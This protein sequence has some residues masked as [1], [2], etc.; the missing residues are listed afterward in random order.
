MSTP[1]KAPATVLDELGITEPTAI[2]IEAIAQYCGATI[3]YEPLDGCEARILGADDRAIITVNSKAQR[4]R[5]RFSAAHEVGHWMRDRGKIAFACTDQMLVREWGDDNPERRANRYAADLLL[6]RKIF[7]PHARA[8]P[9]TFASARTLAK[10]FETSVTSTALRIVE[11]GSLP[12]MMICSEAS[13]R[14]WFTRSTLVPSSLWPTATPGKGSVAAKLLAGG[15][16]AGGPE[17]VDADEWIDHP[18]A[19]NY[20]VIED[21]VSVGSGAVLTMLWWKNERQVLDLSGD[22]EDGDAETPLSG[23]FS[24]GPRRR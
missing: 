16:H 20:T 9:A 10:T 12:S 6:P 24:F 11:V 4:A 5:Q 22:D 7:E 19:S 15:V 23:H 3:V 8:M 1:F 14:R 13:G 21:S 18:N 2:D 17:E